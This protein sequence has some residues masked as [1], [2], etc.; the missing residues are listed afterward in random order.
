MPADTKA[1]YYQWFMT[2][3]HNA[4]LVGYEWHPEG[5]FTSSMTLGRLT[6][7]H[8]EEVGDTWGP[9]IEV[10]SEIAWVVAQSL[11]RG[12]GFHVEV[13]VID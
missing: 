1:R 13:A 12:E 6:F 9:P 8:R 5:E 7:M 11:A 2:D 4:R 10:A 3:E